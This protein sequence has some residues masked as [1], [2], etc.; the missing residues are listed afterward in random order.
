MQIDPHETSLAWTYE[1]DWQPV[2]VLQLYSAYTPYLDQVNTSALEGPSAPTGVLV[3]APF[4]F[5][6][7]DTNPAWV[8]PQYQLALGSVVALTLAGSAPWVFFVYLGLNNAY[9][10]WLKHVVILDVFVICAG[11]ML[12]LDRKSVV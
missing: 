6:T 3:S 10:F 7:G 11:F 12:R 2:P 1:L 8:S 9:T 4:K 5:G